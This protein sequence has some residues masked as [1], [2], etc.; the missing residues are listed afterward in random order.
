MRSPYRGEIIGD[1]EVASRVR[2][3][4]DVYIEFQ[5]GP[6]SGLEAPLPAG[7]VRLYQEDVDG[8][9]LL[10]GETT[11]D[12]TPVGERVK[13]Q[14]GKAFDVVG[15][16]TQTDFVKLGPRALEETYEVV[17]RNRKATPV[18]VQVVERLFRSGDWEIAEASHPYTKADAQTVHFTVEVPAEDEVTITYTVRYR[19]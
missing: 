9:P 19:W 14:V 7:V 16:R 8:A 6:Q 10:I 11:I 13:L 15:E 17:I 18:T 5:T 3:N 2:G 12:H 4:P 1:P